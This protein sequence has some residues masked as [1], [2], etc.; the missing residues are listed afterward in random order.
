MGE[1]VEGAATARVSGAWRGVRQ[2]GLGGWEGEKRG[3]WEKRVETEIEGERLDGCVSLR[4]WIL[5][6]C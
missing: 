1:W 3:V 2:G 6:F 5:L 4:D